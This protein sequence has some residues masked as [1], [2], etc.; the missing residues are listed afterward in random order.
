MSQPTTNSI[1][2]ATQGLVG[3]S[4]ASVAT[5]AALT[6]L[7]ATVVYPELWQAMAKIQVPQVEREFYYTVPAF[8]T[9]LDPVAIGIT[10]MG[11]PTLMEERP[12]ATLL[13]AITSTSNATPIVVL[14]ASAP[15]L[16]TNSEIEITGVSGTRAPWGRWFVT[17]VDSTHYSLNGSVTD[18]T[19]GT[20]GT[21]YTSSAQGFTPVSAPVLWSPDNYQMGT[22]LGVYNWR[23]GVFQFIGATAASQIHVTYWASGTAPANPATP[24]MDDCQSYLSTRLAGLFAG[25]KGWY[26]M[27]KMYNDMAIGPQGIANGRDG[28][29]R[30]FVL[31]QVRSLQRET[32]RRLPFRP[33][34]VSW[35]VAGVSGLIGGFQGGGGVTPGVGAE[36]VYN[37]PAGATA[38]MD[39]LQGEVQYVLLTSDVTVP[40]PLNPRPGPFFMTFVQDSTGNH[41]VSLSG[42]AW[43]SLIDPT[44]W[45]GSGV[46][47]NTTVTVP[48]V[49]LNNGTIILNGIV[50]GPL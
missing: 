5:S 1:F 3:D 35:P 26:T 8:T 37:V 31:T 2:T 10:D 27:A 50:S 36:G 9:Q 17:Q 32:I 49:V 11:N 46:S 47:G 38:L 4:A 15:S 28:L 34:G 20:G 41:A 22:S 33:R 29:L 40:V 19:A 48:C 43:S 13:P 6:P 30:D 44:M 39:L 23:G 18:G 7:F 42:T 45:S 25:S 14:F 24:L 16:S 12:P 21:A